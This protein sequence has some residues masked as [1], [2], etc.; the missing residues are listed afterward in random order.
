MIAEA[1]RIFSQ[2]FKKVGREK[3]GRLTM[4]AA[5]QQPYLHM[6]DGCLLGVEFSRVGPQAIAD[7]GEF[8][9]RNELELHLVHFCVFSQRSGKLV[10]AYQFGK[11]PLGRCVADDQDL[12]GVLAKK[13]GDLKKTDAEQR[14]KEHRQHEDHKER[15]TIAQLVAHLASKNKFDVLQAHCALK[16]SSSSGGV[17]LPL[18]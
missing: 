9:Q 7:K 4:V 16:S 15:A 14:I 1:I 2:L 5:H 17:F 10:L 3:N 11:T 12:A 6:H 13:L 8:L 18:H